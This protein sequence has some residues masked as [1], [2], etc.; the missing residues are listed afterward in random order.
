MSKASKVHTINPRTYK[1]ADDLLRDRV[2][3]VTGAGD[4]IGK[5]AAITFAQH[6][7]TVILAGRTTVKLD[8]VYDLIEK[9][10]YPQAA[11]YPI[12]L[13]G[14]NEDDYSTMAERIE[15]EFG[16]LDGLLHNAGELGERTSIANYTVA[17]W[18]TVMKV[19]VSAQFML[20][21]ALL[22]LMQQA[23]D[24][25][26][27]FTSSGVGRQ[28]RAFWGAYAVSKFA[29]EGLSQVLAAELEE[30]SNI[31]VNT[32]NPGAT[33]TK[34]RAGAYPAENPT[35]LKTPLQIMP[36]YLYLMGPD[37]KGVTGQALEAQQL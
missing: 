35:G 25:S 4:G 13:E 24:A 8:E 33:R 14:A 36:A 6:G 11:I 5:C 10:G 17:S 12:D 1:A 15:S 27:V 30:T 16:R 21:K 22:P 26:I 32:L 2:L 31:R 28:G 19:N 9:D 20:T 23:K 37:S 18:N 29:T 7:A 34:M 3:L